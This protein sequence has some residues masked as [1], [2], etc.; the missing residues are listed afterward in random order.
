MFSCSASSSSFPPDS[1]FPSFSF[2]HLPSCHLGSCLHLLHPLSSLLDF[3]FPF[4]FYQPQSSLSLS[5][6]LTLL[7]VWEQEWLEKEDILPCAFL[8]PG[9][10]LVPCLAL[11]LAPEL[12]LLYPLL[13]SDE[14]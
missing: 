13:D 12:L 6:K 11:E 9:K 4:H 10:L 5:L 14:E 7:S 3:L 8:S 2:Q 1:S